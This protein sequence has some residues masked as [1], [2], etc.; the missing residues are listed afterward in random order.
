L[1]TIPELDRDPYA[2]GQWKS[3]KKLNEAPMSTVMHTAILGD[4]MELGIPVGHR[5]AVK[6]M[7][8]EFFLRQLPYLENPLNEIR[9]ALEMKRLD[10]PYVA[11]VHGVWQDRTHVY[12]VTELLKHDLFTAITHR[13]E[14]GTADACRSVATQILTGGRDLHAN[15]IVHRD[16]SLENFLLHDD[17]N[18]RIIDFGQAICVGPDDV[19]ITVDERGLPGKLHYYPPEL[20]RKLFGE[21]GHA[22]GELY[23]GMKA[24][25]YQVGV[26]LF[27]L[28]TG[29]HPFDATNWNRLYP[30]DEAASDRCQNL[31][32]VIGDRRKVN[33]Q[34]LDLL[35]RLLAPNPDLRPD[36][37]EALSHPWIRNVEVHAPPDASTSIV[38]PLLTSG[39]GFPDLLSRRSYDLP[40]PSGAHV[41]EESSPPA[42]P[43]LSRGSYD[44]PHL[45]SEAS[46][47]A[48]ALLS[49]PP[50]VPLLS[51]GSYDTS[52]TMNREPSAAALLAEPLSSPPA[53]PLLSRGSYDTP[54]SMTREPSA[55]A[56]LSSPPAVPLLPGSTDSSADV[57]D[58]PDSDASPPNGF[59]SARSSFE[60][61]SPSH[62][63]GSK[64]SSSKFPILAQRSYDIPHSIDDPCEGDARTCESNGCS[65]PFS[66]VVRSSESE[67]SQTVGDA[68]ERAEE[69]PLNEFI[70][71]GS[72]LRA[73][74]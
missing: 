44:T 51:R 29:G 2:S 36:A 62:A 48:T 59:L 70:Q 67:T 42:V 5:V 6:K 55:T 40:G 66:S 27:A 17:D 60:T 39:T 20:Y 16:L 63:R 61:P 14:F 35:E 25:M 53:V 32:S 38:E 23:S 19:K 73:Q 3:K 21:R 11:K 1:K 45:S 31:S 72:P 64:S 57:D 22:K 13:A 54:H 10:L 24:D 9:A 52:H 68:A 37:E 65:E 8:K 43:I 28:L 56:I 74:R 15:G 18:V 34:C 49:S 71:Q 58:G 47:S 30:A 41:E 12:L 50:A 46:S 26:T 69:F 33:A 4:A 7:S